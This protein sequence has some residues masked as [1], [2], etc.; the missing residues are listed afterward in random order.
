MR[1]GDSKIGKTAHV[2]SCARGLKN[3]TSRLLESKI[4]PIQCSLFGSLEPKKKAGG[5]GGC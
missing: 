5:S 3:E 1:T 2:L 4:H